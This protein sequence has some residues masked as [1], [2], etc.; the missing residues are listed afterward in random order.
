MRIYNYYIA[1]TDSL[2]KINFAKVVTSATKNYPKPGKGNCITF[3]VP[4][5]K[6]L[7]L[8]QSQ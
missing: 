4:I 5:C 3:S 6:I 8:C 7:K 1:Y 2:I